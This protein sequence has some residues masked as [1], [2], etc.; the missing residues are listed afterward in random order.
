MHAYAS[1]TPLAWRARSR[2]LAWLCWLGQRR[3]ETCA[4]LLLL[5]LAVSV[6]RLSEARSLWRHQRKTHKRAREAV[7]LQQLL[8]ATAWE[9]RRKVRATRCNSWWL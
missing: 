6:S 5:L 1:A 8:R 9:R 2:S 7:Q 3:V 4:T